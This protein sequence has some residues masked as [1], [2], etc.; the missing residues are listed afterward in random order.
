MVFVWLQVRHID[1][2]V[3]KNYIGIVLD[4]CFLQRGL[5]CSSVA[6]NNIHMQLK[7]ILKRCDRFYP[8]SLL[9]LLR[10]MKHI[11]K[12][13]DVFTLYISAPRY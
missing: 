8:S 7:L 1:K 6:V 3:Y 10:L 9:S 11:S 4:V 13:D 12:P 5:L 2:T